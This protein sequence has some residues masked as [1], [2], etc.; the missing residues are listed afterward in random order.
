V[1]VK[2]CVIFCLP[3]LSVPVNCVVAHNTDKMLT[4]VCIKVQSLKDKL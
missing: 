1:Y 3:L 2:L 4:A